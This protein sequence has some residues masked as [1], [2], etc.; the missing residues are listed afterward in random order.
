MLRALVRKLYPFGRFEELEAKVRGLERELTKTKSL[1][2]EELDLLRSRVEIDTSVQLNFETWK[3]NNPL[4]ANPLVSVCVST[5]NLGHILTT[6]CLP[7]ILNQT[8]RNI[9][10]IV[11][12]DGCSDRTEKQISTIRDPRLQFF[13][14]SQRGEYPTNPQQRWQVAG[15]FAINDALGRTTGDL[16]THLD[17]D[18]EF[19]TDRI[20]KL[21]SF[22]AE[23]ES[24]FVWHPFYFEDREGNWS[25]N[26]ATEFAQGKVTTSS[27]FYRSWF[28]NIPWDV[29]AYRLMEPGDWNRFRKIKYLNPSMRRFPDALVKKH[30]T[31][32]VLSADGKESRAHCLC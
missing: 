20:E 28:K 17:D 27:V 4:S 10:V 12:G 24:D 31:W 18:D 13:N 22:I 23:T 6:R 26:D 14:L 15:T 3:R 25:L 8:Y 11:V 29:N 21:V 30:A 19:M 2:R 16:I 9:E 7:S 5:Y 1:Y 32:S